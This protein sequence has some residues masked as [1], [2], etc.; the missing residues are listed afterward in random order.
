MLK[1]SNFLHLRIYRRTF[2]IYLLVVLFF[3]T[4]L[5][6]MF[7]NMTITDGLSSYR[8]VADG[9]FL[10]AE[11]HLSSIATSID[12]FFTK[13]YANSG[14]LQDSFFDFFGATPSQY[15]QSQLTSPYHVHD[16]Y[17]S[18]CADLVAGSGNTIRHM[19]YFSN[20]NIVDMEYNPLG[21]SRYRILTPNKAEQLCSTSLAYTKDIHQNSSYVGKV[22]FLIDLPASLSDLLCPEEGTG[23]CILMGDH[24]FYVGDP[25]YE[26]MAFASLAEKSPS[27]GL[28]D[29]SNGRTMY[30]VRTS[31]RFSYCVVMVS[32]AKIYLT[33]KLG[34]FVLFSCGLV[35]AFV[36]I[37][38]IY[39]RKFSADSKFI[40]SI[41]YSMS[42]ARSETFLPV[43]VGKR[44]DE[45]A[46]IAN[47]LNTLYSNLE[48]LIHQKYL[49][50]IRQQQAEMQKL[51]AQLNPHFLYNTLERIRMRALQEG[52]PVLA[53]ATA[54][55]GMVY[56]N[57]V[58]T[59]PI[60]PMSQELSITN[61]YLDLMC[62][63]YDDR[64]LY[65]CDLDDELND[66]Q[67]PKIWM[68]PIVENFFKHN[69]HSDDQLKV[70]VISGE[71]I[72]SGFCIRFFDNI[73][74]LS[75]EQ[76][77]QL[78]SQFTPDGEEAPAGSGMGLRNVYER[79]HLY[80]GNRLE[81][82]IKNNKPAGVCIQVTLKDEVKG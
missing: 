70:I 15:A 27:T 74:E 12:T 11:Q 80:Y 37:T 28:V 77:V 32:P 50:T 56:R 41:L 44:Q 65:H 7:Y 3:V 67:T 31:D 24:A 43:D 22:T 52:C 4:M 2:L 10:Q 30:R 62:F 76:I 19:V 5:L 79:L 73:G 25:A 35:L 60:I 29:S 55:L 49:L 63:L 46:D 75:Q 6:A 59:E 9:R 53:Q 39:I 17:L 42:N 14:A 18:G 8:N 48:T 40:K 69:F 34:T 61:Q 81:M 16:S 57:I 47:H 51:S 45:F 54:D 23:A 64:L 33:H 21:Y 36:L 58:K 20:T 72:T 68:Q 38:A 13:L 71:R 1:L 66:I 82:S 26:S 78:N